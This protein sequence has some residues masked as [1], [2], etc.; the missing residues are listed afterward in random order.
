MFEDV[1]QTNA[2]QTSP[3]SA[4]IATVHAVT[5]RETAVSKIWNTRSCVR[6]ATGNQ[7]NGERETEVMEPKEKKRETKVKRKKVKEAA[8]NIKFQQ[9]PATLM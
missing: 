3:A 8:Q 6:E 9:L 4:C 7:K 2:T 5:Q 1:T